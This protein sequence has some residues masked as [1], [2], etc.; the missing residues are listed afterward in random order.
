LRFRLAPQDGA[1]FELLTASAGHLVEGAD[2]LT[3]ML[4]A[5]R[6]QRV[7]L[8]ER[9]HEVE[10]AADESTRAFLSRLNQTFVTPFDRDDMYSLASGID[11]C[12]DAIDEA[13]DLI[14]LYKVGVLPTGVGQLVGVLR[15]CAELTA[16]A[17]PRLRSMTDLREYWVEVDRLEREAD[18]AYRRLVADLFDTEPDPIKVIKLKG[19]LDALEEAADSFER[20][21]NGVETIAL[22]ES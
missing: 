11:D 1:F 14:V 5:D 4:S 18:R 2:L 16:Q 15:R 9:L 20:L 7:R 13:G 12:M 6:T 8:A 22:K 17:M 19:V 21:A 3:R 10:H